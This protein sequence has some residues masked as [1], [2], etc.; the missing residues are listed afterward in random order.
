MKH[1]DDE[2][3]ERTLRRYRPADPRP[4]FRQAVVEPRPSAASWAA[5]AA[6]LLAAVVLL[7]VGM[8]HEIN[9]LPAESVDLERESM[10]RLTEALGGGMEAR[11][12]AQIL[13]LQDAVRQANAAASQQGSAR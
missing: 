7:K 1:V 8:A 5:L 3:V 4:E 2:D 6:G 13:M 11:R 9:R 10:E 12:V